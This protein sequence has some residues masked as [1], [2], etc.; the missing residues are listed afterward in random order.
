LDCG[1]PSFVCAPTRAFRIS[2]VFGNSNSASITAC[3]VHIALGSSDQVDET[4]RFGCACGTSA[5]VAAPLIRFRSSLP[6]S[7]G[8]RVVHT[9]FET[10]LRLCGVP[11]RSRTEGRLS[12]H[13]PLALSGTIIGDGSRAS[14]LGSRMGHHHQWG[15]EPWPSAG[16]T[17]SAPLVLSWLL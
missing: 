2:A 1:V 11:L 8:R 7:V 10:C 3:S 4:M 16:S 14:S 13:S 12:R 17:R 5:R 15:F 9:C 6:I